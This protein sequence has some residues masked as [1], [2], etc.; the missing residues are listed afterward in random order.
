MEVVVLFMIL[1]TAPVT[2]VFGQG[3]LDL[4]IFYVQ[5]FNDNAFSE[6]YYM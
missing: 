3:K 1:L 2:V 5:L 4:I 6:C